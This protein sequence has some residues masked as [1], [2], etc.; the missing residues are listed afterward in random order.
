MSSIAEFARQWKKRTYMA[1]IS[2]QAVRLRD[3]ARQAEK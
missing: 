2:E 3:G 1:N